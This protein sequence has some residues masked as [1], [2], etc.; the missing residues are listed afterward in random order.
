MEPD[1][2]PPAHINVQGAGP[3]PIA[4][5]E[6]VVEFIARRGPPHE[7]RPVTQAA[8]VPRYYVTSPAS[9]GLYLNWGISNRLGKEGH[10]LA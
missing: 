9:H 6:P 5:D 10:T 7:V 8:Q 2:S 4:I 3:A 1:R